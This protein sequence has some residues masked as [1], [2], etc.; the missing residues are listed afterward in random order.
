[1]AGTLYR[2]RTT[3]LAHLASEYQRNGTVNNAG[4]TATASPPLWEAVF[5][6]PSPKGVNPDVGGI[7]GL[8]AIPNPVGKGESLLFVWVP[9]GTAMNALLLHF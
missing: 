2:R 7:R 4:S 5:T 3:P 1:M 9:L 8:T 6:A